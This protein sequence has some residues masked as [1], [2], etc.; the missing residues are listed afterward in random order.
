MPD[1]LRNEKP[2]ALDRDL[3]DR[4][5]APVAV[6]HATAARRR[7][8][9]RLTG[10]ILLAVIAVFYGYRLF[11][12]HMVTAMMAQ[13]RPPTPITAA[14]AESRSV[15]R[16]LSGIGTL[17]AVRQVT[18]AP[19]VG[20][21]ITQVFFEPGATVNAG[22]PLIQINDAPER[23]DLANYQAQA[24]LAAANLARDKALSAQN[25]QS[26]QVVDQQQSLLDQA[27]ANI[28]KTEALIA[29]KLIRAPFSG[30]LGIRQ[31]NLGGYLNPG[32]PIVTLTDL[33]SLWIN[34]TLPEQ[35][36]S[37]IHVGQPA[38]LHA[39]A[40]PGRVFEA[41]VTAIEPQISAQTRTIM[42][43]A[44]MD[45]A[46]H[47]L[48]PGMFADVDVV[49]PEAPNVVTV[50]ETAVDYSLYGDSV[51]LVQEA[52]KDDQ[53]KPI[54]KVARTFVKIGERFDGKVAIL[55]GLKPGDRV[56]ASGQLRLNNETPVTILPGDPLST[57]PATTAY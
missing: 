53:G 19:E 57:P 14:V 23:G 52:G 20:G 15:P 32:G 24:R 2:I 55:S 37:Q 10:I 31:V 9:F 54:L 5:A 4:T 17:Q 3:P 21:R 51:F 13:P 7:R 43:Q 33:S 11:S 1:D 47:A 8:A 28:A 25:F 30:Q 50:P 27:Q 44:T 35:V 46:D 22:D 39:D 18:V 29:Q 38:R 6:P 48:M 12:Q 36:A 56:A 40:Y 41:K 42:V 16:Y 26:R 45:N 49:L 34:F